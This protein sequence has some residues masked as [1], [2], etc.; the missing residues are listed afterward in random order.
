VIFDIDPSKVK[1]KDELPR[2]RKDMGE[3]KKL[4]ESMERFGQLQPIVIN[5]EY[6]LIAGGRRLA[7]C[8]LGGRIARVCFND[9][10]DPLLMRELELEENLQRKELTPSEEVL[11]VEEI[12]NLKRQ[13][14][15]EA[16]SGK[17]GSGWRLDDTADL[18]GKTRS[19]VIEDIN[20]AQF[21]KMYPEL[22]ECKT[23]SEIRKAAKGLEKISQR[24]S[25]LQSYEET[26]KNDVSVYQIEQADAKK[27]LLLRADNTI[28]LLLTDPPY[29]INI[30][31]NMLTIGDRTGSGLSTSGFLYDDKPEE[32]LQM[33]RLL[34]KESIRFCKTTAHAWIFVG[35]EWFE[36]VRKIFIEAGWLVY[37]KPII[38]IK[39]NSGQC[40]VP[41]YWPASAYE[42]IMYARRTDSRLVVEGKVDWIQCP[43]VSPSERLHQAEKPSALIKELIVRTSLPGQ[44]MYDPFM[45]SGP[46]ILEAVKMKMF[47]IG[48]DIA[49]ESY[50]A[51]V[52]RLVNAKKRGEI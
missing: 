15:G 31:E 40:N 6:E 49:V 10:I 23:K 37:I 42:M 28:D 38:W 1:V 8:L 19:T 24:I 30:T 18:I 29:G 9:A 48:C 27:H 35:P 14:H 21:V 16:V 52:Q 22:I 13:L 25:A 3:I 43:I 45:G 32:A 41:E 4:L 17:E 34:A 12:H 11:A 50:S 51:T 5:R 2:I 46:T 26:T 7:A 20:L 36:T 47:A 39:G 44:I 33:Y